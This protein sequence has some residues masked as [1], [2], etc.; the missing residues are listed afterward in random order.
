MGPR[1]PLRLRQRTPQCDACLI[2]LAIVQPLHD[3]PV[4]LPVCVAH[5]L[6]G[7]VLEPPAL[8]SCLSVLLPI[9][10]ACSVA[11]VSE[12]LEPSQKSKSGHTTAGGSRQHTRLV[13]ER[14]HPSQQQQ[15][16]ADGKG[17]GDDHGAVGAL[18]CV[19]VVVVV[20]GGD[21][22]TLCSPGDAFA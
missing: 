12:P 2:P 9:C 5:H 7:V 20:E 19:C 18:S 6:A 11:L 16:Q 17:Q 13:L 14:L 4:L 15:Q 3:V 22:I 10:G 21:V 8:G 1:G